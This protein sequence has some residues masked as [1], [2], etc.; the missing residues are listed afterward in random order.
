MTGVQTCA[1]PIWSPTNNATLALPRWGTTIDACAQGTRYLFDGSYIRLKN[2]EIAYTIKG[3]WLKKMGIS[4]CRIYVNGNNLYMWTKM[5][6]DREIG[7]SSDGVY[8]TMRR[9]N[10]GFDITL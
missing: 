4:T 3:A 10:L 6:D 7:S 1:L 8:P 5:P 9:F 2:V